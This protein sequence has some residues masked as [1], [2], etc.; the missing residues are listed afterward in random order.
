MKRV[1]G[2][3]EEEDEV[4]E[5]SKVEEGQTPSCPKE[6]A[7][8]PDAEESHTVLLPFIPVTDLHVDHDE[9]HDAR[10]HQDGQDCHIGEIVGQQGLVVLFHPAPGNT[11][12]TL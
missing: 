5:G 10:E 12:C 4:R 6:A 3:G 8:A 11:K 2:A 9:H 7:E 1:E